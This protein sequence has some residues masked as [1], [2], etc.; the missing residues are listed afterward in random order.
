M[1]RTYHLTNAEKIWYNTRRQPNEGENVDTQKIEIEKIAFKLAE[2]E[3]EYT[4]T[5]GISSIAGAFAL[6]I[7]H[8]AGAEV[9]GLMDIIE[10]TKVSPLISRFLIDRLSDHWDKYC[11][12]GRA[13]V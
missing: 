12:I 6:Y 13:H 1:A 10:Q 11:Q 9:T 8:D 3:R 5:P 7:A 2:I 4:A